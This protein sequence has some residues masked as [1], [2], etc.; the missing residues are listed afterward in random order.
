MTRATSRPARRLAV[1][2]AG[3]LLSTCA[4]VLAPPAAAS[5]PVPPTPTGLPTAI[6][7]A[8]PYIGQ[9]TCDPVAKVGV[10]AFRDLLLRTYPTTTSLGIVKDCGLGGQSEHKEGRA[11]DWGVSAYDASDVARANALLGWL[12]ATDSH[13]NTRA[14]AR[15]L[16]VMYMIWNHHIF[17]MYDTAGWRT[18][19]GVD[20]HTSHVH[21]SFGWNGAKKVTSFWDRTVAP[22]D[23]GPAGPAAAPP[24]E[25]PPPAPVVPTRTPANLAVQ[26]SYGTLTLQ[27]GST[28]AAV[29]V[30][31]SA[32]HIAADGDY[33]NQSAAAVSSFETSQKLAADGIFHATSWPLLF[34]APIDPFGHIDPVRRLPGG[35]ALSGWAMDADATGPA[36]VAYAV[37][38]GTTRFVTADGPR[39][40]VAAAYP[41]QGGAHGF[42]LVVDVPDGSHR[43]CTS[44]L[45]MAGTP[46]VNTP[47]GCQTLV[48]SHSPVG[49]LDPL[50][51][52][53]GSTTV[54]GWALDA[55]TVAPIGVALSVDGG[56]ATL[57]M[58]D[59][60]RPDVATPWPGYGTAHGWGRT[61]T[62]PEGAHRVCLTALNAASAAGT[63]P[64]GVDGSLGCLTTTVMH[65]PVGQLETV[66][67]EPGVVHVLGW[68][69]DPD[70][71]VA[72]TTHLV[73]DGVSRAAT[74]AVGPRTG[75]A[76]QWSASGSS[77]GVDIQLPLAAG[78]HQVCLAAANAPGT[79][80]GPASLGCRSV[81]V[82][83]APVGQLTVDRPVPGAS[84]RLSGWALDPDTSGPVSVTVVLDGV[85]R[86]AISAWAASSAAVV[87]RPGYGTLHGFTVTVPLTPGRRTLCVQLANVA[88]TPGTTTSLGCRVVLSVVPRLANLA[89]V[90]SYGA[91][92]LQRGSLGAA[93]TALQRGLSIP[94]D[95]A[96][97]SQTADAVRNFERDQHLA[98]DGV[99][100]PGAWRLLLPRPIVPFGALD[101]LF[102]VPGGVAVT[103][104]SAD[105]DVAG[106]V[107][108]R[109]VADGG[110]AVATTASASRAGLARAWPEIS[111]RH[112]FRVVLPL[113]AGTHRV[114][115]VGVNAPGTPG[116]DG[117]LGCRSLTVSSTPY[118]AVTTVT[119]RAGSVALAGWALD[120]D[121]AAAVT[122]RVSVDGVVAGTTR[123]GTVSAG[124]GSSHPGYGDAHGWSL[125]AL[126]KAGVHRVCAT[127]L[128]AAGTP[129]GD[130]VATCRS[131]TVP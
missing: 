101:P 31:Q 32:L 50:V 105:T 2:M 58:A 49:H 23:Y 30:L 83:N 26:S 28:G 4:V 95:G 59:G 37:D 86:P 76:A 110:T 3:A 5:V 11:W 40:D 33:G 121:T 1:L 24:A 38:G 111:D 109:L 63:D 65:R 55:D 115:A 47:L 14:M 97:G 129:G 42:S 51:T 44:A 114:C 6:E 88:G 12:L 77:H 29:A 106:S 116:G 56:A 74:A 20:P 100:H 103:G 64:R 18:Y 91:T 92:T 52:R 62:L 122:V 27:Q 78:T 72:V 71:S 46:G 60:T 48:V 87:A 17:G 84:V 57:L 41:G 102:R 75:I 96:F 53:L 131:V 93:V 10:A 19:S 13:G 66:R 35:V 98:V 90:R 8:Q 7:D 68:A 16:G 99:F 117:P 43:V 82:A 39:A 54:N 130:G 127:A 104:W 34:P 107:Q 80:G 126:A 128:A 61:L 89:V 79:P 112:G 69:L 67:Q 118:G 94:A 21:F 45:N 125:T 119:A 124:F 9:S 25:V 73:I 70:T 108:V 15:R 113:R 22:V 120:P 123:A 36:T 81:T 85:R